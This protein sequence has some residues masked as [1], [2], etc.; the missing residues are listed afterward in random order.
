MKS[1]TINILPFSHIYF[2][3]GYYQKI[4]SDYENPHLARIDCHRYND[5]P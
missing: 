5:L 1:V 4:I 3:N 2:N